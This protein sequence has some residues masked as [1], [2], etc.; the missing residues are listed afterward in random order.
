MESNSAGYRRA[1]HLHIATAQFVFRHATR[2]IVFVSD[3]ISLDAAAVLGLEPLLLYAVSAEGAPIRWVSFSDRHNPKPLSRV[4]E[5]A[6]REAAGLRGCPDAVILSHSLSESYPALC[7]KLAKAHVAVAVSDSGDRRCSAMLR[8]AQRVAHATAWWTNGAS[9]AVRTLA[10]LN[11]VAM[12]RHNDEYRLPLK[13]AS[14]SGERHARAL[15]W[16]AY[17]SR[18]LAFN[19][20]DSMDWNPGDWLSAWSK[21]PL[22]PAPRYFHAADKVTW[23][24]TGEPDSEDAPEQAETEVD[25]YLAIDDAGE[26]MGLVLKVWPNKAASV[27]QEAGI[28]LRELQWFVNGKVELPREQRWALE[29]LLGVEWNETY[30]GF[31]I[32]G[33][34][35][36]IG[37]GPKPIL[38]AYDEFTRGGDLDFSVEPIP[39][40]GRADPSWRYVLAQPCGELS[41]VMMFPRGSAAAES[42]DAGNFI[43]FGGPS[44]IP[45]AIYRDMV[46]T[47]GRACRSPASNRVEMLEFNRRYNWHDIIGAPF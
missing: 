35:V 9:K 27:A 19:L 43:N 24:L 39:D 32:N 1:H 25:G 4:L 16:E 26:K 47:C 17:S 37:E 36:L 23:L 28:T 20:L 38:A 6:W 21:A 12:Q 5:E 14:A 13:T 11:S 18:P 29:N 3:P 33:P 42:L 41:S 40:S 31:D 30:G 8:E 44:V 46:A 45:E 34:F 2:G 10:D 7:N 15:A 22:P